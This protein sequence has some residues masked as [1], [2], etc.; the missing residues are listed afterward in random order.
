[1][2]RRAPRAPRAYV[3]SCSFLFCPHRD[4]AD[5]GH[6]HGHG[7]GVIYT[8]SGNETFALKGGEADF[9]SS[10]SSPGRRV[11][12]AAPGYHGAALRSGLREAFVLQSRFF[13]DVWV[14]GAP[15]ST[16]YCERGDAMPLSSN[17]MVLQI[18][19]GTRSLR[20]RRCTDSLRRRCMGSSRC[21]CSPRSPCTCSPLPPSW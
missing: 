8:Q 9:E 10:F 1:M 16:T 15:P 13:C 19:R 12:A 6:H 17:D 4:A 7:H 2:I 3:V 18:S 20:R 11:R 14:Q 5:H 21:T